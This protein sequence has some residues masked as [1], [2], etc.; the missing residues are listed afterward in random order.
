MKSMWMW[1]R[2][3]RPRSSSPHDAVRALRVG[4]RPH[5]LRGDVGEVADAV[6]G[7][8][9][10]AGP[11][12]GGEEADREIGARPLEV[13]GVEAPL[14]EPLARDV[15]LLGTPRPGGVRVGLVE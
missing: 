5:L 12:R 10:G 3:T 14:V 13:E 4:R 2:L 6:R 9:A 11:L 1:L 15:E 7:R 8:G